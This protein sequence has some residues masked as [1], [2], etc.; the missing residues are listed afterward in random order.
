MVEGNVGEKCFIIEVGQVE[1]S[2]TSEVKGGSAIRKPT[3]LLTL[4]PGDIFGELAL[5]FDAPRAATATA[6]TSVTLWAI[7]RSIFREL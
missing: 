4:G 7:T 1:I 6:L 3:K 2:K 5:L